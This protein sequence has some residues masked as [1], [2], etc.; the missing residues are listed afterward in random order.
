VDNCKLCK[1]IWN[2]LISID[3]LL[4]TF[5]G[6]DPDETISSRAGKRQDTS[7][8]AKYL[9]KFLNLLD[10]NHCSKSVEDDEGS[11]EI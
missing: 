2:I 3:Q 8:W 1:Y 6:G 5:L 7:N 10:T 4:N 11:R 9:C